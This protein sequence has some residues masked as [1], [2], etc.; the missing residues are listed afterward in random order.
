MC[1]DARDPADTADART[2]FI[3]RGRVQGVGFRW[4]TREAAG[5]LGLRGTVRNRADG[6]VEVHVAGSARRV[7]QFAAMLRSG[8]PPARV[9]RVEEI[10]CDP[11]LPPDFQVLF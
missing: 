5:L 2:G 9:D 4:W 1:E 7:R 8:P 3:L 10:P 11:A 6:S